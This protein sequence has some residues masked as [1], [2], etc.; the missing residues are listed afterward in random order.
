MVHVAAGLYLTLVT[1]GSDS[2]TAINDEKSLSTP[3]RSCPEGR[4]W[5][6]FLSAHVLHLERID[7]S[8]AETG[9]M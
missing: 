2:Q 4:R 6:A 3:V 1:D 9:R 7:G 8:S 5:D